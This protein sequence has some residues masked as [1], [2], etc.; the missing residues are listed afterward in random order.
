VLL[1]HLDRFLAAAA[2][3]YDGCPQVAFFDVGSFGVW[4]EG[5]NFWS[6]KLNYDAA[7]VIRHLALH[8]RHFKKTLLVANHTFADHGRGTDSLDYAWAEGF[9]LRSDSILVLEGDELYFPEHATP[10]WPRLPVILESQHYGMSVRDGVWGDGS[11]YLRAVED[12]HA[13]YISIHWYA[14]EFLEKNEGLI[15]QINRRLGYRL[16]LV[17][18]EWN[19]V[20][21]A[22][23]SSLDV[24]MVWRNGGVAPCLPG[25]H[26]AISLLG[27]DGAITA[28]SVDETFDVRVLAPG[29]AGAAPL[30]THTV[31]LRRHPLLRPGRYTVAVSVGSCTGTPQ[32]ALPLPRGERERC[33]PLGQLTVEG[34]IGLG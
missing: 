21:A 13:S 5:H 11:G 4:G 16:Q 23:E 1:L 2:A 20:W 14:E 31:R 10:V 28:V 15:E 22:G 9:T 6:S 19:E 7:T 25:G 24:R 32:L 29:S 30:G 34:E 3:R 27:E 8:R 26:V 12:Y 17:E 18:S 33:Y